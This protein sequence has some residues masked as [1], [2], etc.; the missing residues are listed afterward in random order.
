M[1]KYWICYEN[2][3]TNFLQKRH[4]Q[5][6]GLIFGKTAP[7]NL[8]IL[9]KINLSINLAFLLKI[10]F[11]IN[12]A[13]ILKISFFMDTFLAFCLLT[14][15]T[16]NIHVNT[17]FGMMFH[18][19]HTF[20]DSSELLTWFLI[21]SYWNILLSVRDRSQLLYLLTYFHMSTCKSKQ[22][23]SSLNIIFRIH[24]LS[25]STYFTTH[26]F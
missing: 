11:S 19:K 4:K 17:L 13:F 3:V 23:K 7:S 21:L 1:E 14:T 9:L 18:L 10:N 15:S 8:G 25:K 20:L 24:F 2:I 5:G 12:F 26:K 22:S 6:L 16:Q